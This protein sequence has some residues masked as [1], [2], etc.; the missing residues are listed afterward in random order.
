[1][2]NVEIKLDLAAL[3]RISQAAQLA[4]LETVGALRTEVMKAQVVPMN[5]GNLQASMNIS[6]SVDGEEVITSLNTN[7]PYARFQYHGKLMVAGNGSSWAK[8]EEKKKATGIPLEHQKTNNP[9]AQ[10]EWLKPWLP[11]GNL[12]GYVPET[13]AERLEDK[14]SG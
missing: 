9:N 12:E 7:E 8:K 10:A 3:G 5:N 6:Q 11:G 14:I 1:M 4:A 13:F 2:P